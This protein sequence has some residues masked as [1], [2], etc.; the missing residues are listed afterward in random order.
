MLA[1][2]ITDLTIVNAY[3]ALKGENVNIGGDI[4]DFLKKNTPGGSMWYLRLALERYG[5]DTLSEMIDPKYNEKRKR[6]KK[7]ML[8]EQGTE[9]WWSPGDKLPKNFP[10]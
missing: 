7:R 10:F 5:F 1:F 2:Q 3:R 6:I 4:A 9:F 8:K